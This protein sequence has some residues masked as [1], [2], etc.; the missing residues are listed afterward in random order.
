[1]GEI[2]DGGPLN[3]KNRKQYLNRLGIMCK[4]LDLSFNKSEGRREEFRDFLRSRI[5]KL[6]LNRIR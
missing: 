2:N 1:M 5:R 6:D 4:I 3:L